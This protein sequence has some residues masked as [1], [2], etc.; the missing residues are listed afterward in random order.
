METD[1]PRPS[2]QPA[3]STRRLGSRDDDSHRRCLR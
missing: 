3:P 2:R 1:E